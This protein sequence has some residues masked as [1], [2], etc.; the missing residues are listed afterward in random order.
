MIL[1]DQPQAGWYKR[2]LVRGGPWVAVRI[3]LDEA[4]DPETGEPMDRPTRWLCEADGRA[5]EEFDHWPWVAGHSFHEI[6]IA[7]FLGLSDRRATTPSAN[8][9]ECDGT[10]GGL[11]Y[12]SEMEFA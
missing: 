9:H 11:G 10:D 3:Y 4:R 8:R 6:D 7:N 12:R 1:A 5:A 2:R